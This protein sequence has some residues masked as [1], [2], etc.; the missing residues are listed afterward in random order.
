[1]RLALGFTDQTFP[2]EEIG[3]FRNP[4]PECNTGL[5]VPP[6]SP[7]AS[8]M[9]DIAQWLSILSTLPA[10]SAFATLPSA[11]VDISG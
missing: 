1:L 11:L 2:L 8:E 7:F 4:R 3:Y 5:S 9:S 10:R 6:I